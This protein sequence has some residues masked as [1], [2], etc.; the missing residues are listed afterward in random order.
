[1]GDYP[2]GRAVTGQDHTG[3]IRD[4]HVHTRN[5][6]QAMLVLQQ[7]F[8]Q[9]NAAFKPF[10]NPTNGT[11]MNQNVS[12]SGTPEIIHNGGTSTEW[13][14]SALQ[15]TWNFADSDKV[16]ITSAN[17]QDAATFAEE[18]PT[19]I[20]PSGFTALTGKI[21][22]TIYS[23]A[24]NEISVFFDLA[25]VQVG[26]TLNLEDFIN[27]N[28]L[29]TEQSF[30]IGLSNFNFASDSIDGFSIRISRS[31]G[32]KPTMTF[33]DI[34]MEKTGETLVY[35]SQ[36]V[37]GERYHVNALRLTMV[38]ADTNIVTVAGATENAT[39]PGLSYNKLLGVSALGNGIVFQRTQDNDVNLTA[40]IKQL[41]D[42]TQLGFDILNAISD[43]T[44][45]MLNLEVAFQ[46]PFV[47]DGLKGDKMT[48]TI[49]DN[50]S[51]LL[52]FTAV[53]RGA[54]EI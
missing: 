42:F 23:E 1:M 29:G 25:G 5:G 20:T 2:I 36:P 54:I 53:A 28:L 12:F 35:T 43:G 4:A 19:T 3:A 49:A 50:L 33:D 9:F 41:S 11:A 44:N 51:G 37:L 34:Q 7:P 52:Q 40:T 10:L 48:F 46:R 8:L 27:T 32:T 24:F 14:G 45:T 17:D 15:G 31:G 22:L 38:D 6:H 39:L 16:S 47:L 21:N 18:T 30:A 13:T 26:D